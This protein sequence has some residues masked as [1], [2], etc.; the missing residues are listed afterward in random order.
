VYTNPDPG[1]GTGQIR[2]LGVKDDHES[3]EGVTV[4]LAIIR[5]HLN[6]AKKWFMLSYLVDEVMKTQIPRD[7]IVMSLPLGVSR[8]GASSGVA[9]LLALLRMHFAVR[10]KPRVAATG[11]VT[12]NGEMWHVGDVVVKVSWR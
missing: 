10:L 4:G 3:M 5:S 7:V 9:I 2:T 1:E 12:A 8:A 11:A 6:E